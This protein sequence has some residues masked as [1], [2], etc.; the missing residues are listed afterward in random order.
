MSSYLIAINGP[1][2]GKK[3]YL[4]GEKFVLG[5]H[6]ECD[7]LVEVGAVSR[8]H[9]QITKDSQEYYIEDLGSRNGT[10]VNEKQIADKYHLQDSDTIRICDVDFS[11]HVDQPFAAPSG[12]PQGNL[13]ESSA[14]GTI[15]F[16]EDEGESTIMSKLEVSSEPGSIHLTASAEVKLLALLEITRQLSGALTIE[17][18]LPKVL[19]S[20]FK[21][22]LQADRGFIIV[23]E[24][25]GQLIPKWTKSRREGD[26]EVRISKT[27]VNHVIDSKEAILSADAATDT[28]FEMSQS[29]T[30]FKIRSI[31]CVPLINSDG[32]AFGVIQIDTLDQ[33]KRFQQE[34][35]EVLVSIASQASAAIDNANMHEIALKRKSMDRD[36]KLA[37]QVQKGFLPKE[38]PD[39]PDYTFYDFY[40]AANAVGGDYYDYI[41]LPND[42]LAI[43]VGDVVGHG[44]AASLLMAKLSADARYCLV[45]EPDPEKAIYMLNNKFA[46]AIPDDQFV[47]L[48]VNI[49]DHKNHTMTVLN[50]GHQA[51]L[52]RRNDGKIDMIAEEEINLPLGVMEDMDYEAVTV[53]IAPG[54]SFTLFTDGLNE[55]MNSDGDQLGMDPILNQCAKKHASVEDMGKAI[56]QD[57]QAFMGDHKQFDDMCLVIYERNAE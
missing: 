19:D 33:R 43:I 21:I 32:T 16:D 54:E 30:D 17:E 56:I 48:V 39:I 46:E 11:F 2:S 10:Y 57:T 28:R 23:R 41:P 26:D 45:L 49:L 12:L 50:A 4:A 55:A 34:D 18:V 20:L 22:F 25:D 42:R 5:R 24:A 38:G 44:I 27:V 37:T 8:H 14:F 29:I 53:P 1:D 9:A 3:I 15:V 13:D 47:T 40:L 31:M 51:P 7:I 35:L 6:P 52:L 36:L